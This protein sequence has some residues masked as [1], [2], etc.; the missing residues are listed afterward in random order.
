VFRAEISSKYDL[1]VAVKNRTI[2]GYLAIKDC[3]IDRLYV[4]PPLQ[5]RGCGTRLLDFAKRLSPQGLQLHT[6]Q[7]NVSARAFYEKHG[8]TAVRFGISPAPEFEPDVEYHW[9][10]TTTIT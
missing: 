2:L 3:Y 6:H 4:D 10:N 7:Q 8:F 9:T 1:W 5:R